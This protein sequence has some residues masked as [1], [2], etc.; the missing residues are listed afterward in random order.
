MPEEAHPDE[1]VIPLAEE[2]VTI[3]KREV[4]TGR[5]RV[6]LTTDIETVIAR[7]TL[8]GREVEVE[9]VPVNQTLADGEPPPQ[10]REE[11]NAL[12]IPVIEEKAVVVK[13]LVIREEIRLRFVTTETP[14]EE[15][16]SVRR[17]RATIHRA[18]QDTNDASVLTGKD[19]P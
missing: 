2:M 17:Q 5:V 12:V 15:A 1:V 8:R 4:E 14:F 10:S 19:S 6:A 11:G 7:E 16:V 13:R 18:V 9:R 3:S